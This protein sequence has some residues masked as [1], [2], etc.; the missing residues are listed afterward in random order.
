MAINNINDVPVAWSPRISIVFV[1]WLN[2]F[3]VLMRLRHDRFI[4]E[5]L[6]TNY[7]CQFDVCWVIC[8]SGPNRIRGP[9]RWIENHGKCANSFEPSENNS[10]ASRRHRF[11]IWSTFI[12]IC[13]NSYLLCLIRIMLCESRHD[14]RMWR[15]MGSIA[16]SAT[17]KTFIEINHIQRGSC[18]PRKKIDSRSSQLSGEYF[19]VI[20]LKKI[21][22]SLHEQ[23]KR[24]GLIHRILYHI[25]RRCR[26]AISAK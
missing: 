16:L 13:A 9:Q 24:A 2:N 19:L 25:Y 20:N 4:D 22:P 26:E 21:R 5:F 3:W 14:L 1:S 6:R 7:L 15:L 17:E 10:C 8:F 12:T 11:C 18:P 23:M